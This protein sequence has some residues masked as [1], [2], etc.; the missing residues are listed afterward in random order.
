MKVPLDDN[1]ALLEAVIQMARNIT[2][3]EPIAEDIAAAR[4]TLGLSAKP[5]AK[6]RQKPKAKAVKTRNQ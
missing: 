2:G 5:P 1:E 6:K 4:K 3:K